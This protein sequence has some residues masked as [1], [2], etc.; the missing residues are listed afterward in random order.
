MLT[1]D[2]K[3]GFASDSDVQAAIEMRLS[4]IT[5]AKRTDVGVL[6]GEAVSALLDINESIPV[7]SSQRHLVAGALEKFANG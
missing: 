3:Y 2:P 4:V 5:M 1:P 6:L 7:E